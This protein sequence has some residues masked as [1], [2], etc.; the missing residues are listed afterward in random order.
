[1]FPGGRKRSR[2]TDKDCLRREIQEEL[3]KLKLGRLNLWR[4]VNQK[5]Q[6]SG[7]KM[8]DAIMCLY[9]KDTY[10][11]LQHIAQAIMFDDHAFGQ[12]CRA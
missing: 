3:P 2:E 8:S 11:F 5:N 4:K 1:M 6:R 12:T 9:A 10:L 7:R